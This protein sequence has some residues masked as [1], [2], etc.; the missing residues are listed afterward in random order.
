MENGYS[1]LH[2]SISDEKGKVV[3]GH[4]KSPSLV[5][6]TAEILI[7]EIQNLVFERE[8]DKMTGYKELVVKKV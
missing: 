4:L 2:I 3:G 1:H 5:G 7:G 6:V 8:F